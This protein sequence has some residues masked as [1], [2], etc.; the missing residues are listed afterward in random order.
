M[1]EQ[2]RRKKDTPTANTGIVCS[3]RLP[4]SDVRGL[5]LEREF[6][7]PSSFLL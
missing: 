3:S 5:W 4:A 2:G 6:Q 1:K 7:R